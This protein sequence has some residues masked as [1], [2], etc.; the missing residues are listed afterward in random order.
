M[1]FDLFLASDPLMSIYASAALV[2]SRREEI[3]AAEPEMPVLHHLLNHIPESI[4]IE[5]VLKRARELFDEYRP[6]MI[7]GIVGIFNVLYS[8]KF[9]QKQVQAFIRLGG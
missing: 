7:Q 4:D 6:K 9:V 3:F 2:E 8:L 1:C 5:A